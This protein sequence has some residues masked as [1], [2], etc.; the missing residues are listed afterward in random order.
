MSVYAQIAGQHS[1]LEPTNR[2]LVLDPLIN[3]NRI[4]AIV[5][6]DLTLTNYQTK[7]HVD[8]L[9]FYVLASA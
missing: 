3:A 6:P 5:A 7:S 4:A 1:W 8:V 9:L 2:C